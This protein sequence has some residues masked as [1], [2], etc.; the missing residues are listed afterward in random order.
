MSYG[1]R[2]VESEVIL[3]VQQGDVEYARE[4]IAGMLP[5]ERN[6]LAAAAANLEQMLHLNSCQPGLRSYTATRPIPLLIQP[7]EEFRWL[8][9][10][11]RETSR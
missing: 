10:C 11:G 1:T 2:F 8:G 7:T 6:E 5:G 4:L 9:N 3:A